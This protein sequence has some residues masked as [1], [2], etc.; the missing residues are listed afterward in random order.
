MLNHLYSRINHSN[1]LIFGVMKR[2][3]G[4]DY[5][6]TPFMLKDK[7]QQFYHEYEKIRMIIDLGSRHKNDDD[8]AP[9]TPPPAK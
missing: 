2:F 9:P 4:L 8:D 7:Q 5:K 3:G 1:L 6:I